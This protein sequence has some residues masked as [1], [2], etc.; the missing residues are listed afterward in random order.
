MTEMNSVRNWYEDNSEVITT[1]E[2]LVEDGYLDWDDQSNI[3]HF[4]RHPYKW[5]AE[6]TQ[7]LAVAGG[8]PGDDVAEGI[9]EGLKSLKA[10]ATGLLKAISELKSPADLLI[11]E[12]R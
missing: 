11:E 9:E 12:S 10:G 7:M 1:L 2:L 5:S 8:A 6:R 4:L 3:L